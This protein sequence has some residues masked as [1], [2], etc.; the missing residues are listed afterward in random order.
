MFKHAS[1]PAPRPNLSTDTSL[2]TV[3]RYAMTPYTFKDGLQVP[4]GT[5]ISFPNLRYNTQPC[6]KPVHVMVNGG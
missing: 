2:A 1:T 5:V 3:Q 6:P 4:V